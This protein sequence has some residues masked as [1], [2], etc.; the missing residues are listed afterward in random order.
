LAFSFG[1]PASNHAAYVSWKLSAFSDIC[2]SFPLSNYLYEA[3]ARL[4]LYQVDQR[5][6]GISSLDSVL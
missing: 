6:W 3:L 1:S 5:R 2:R 4:S